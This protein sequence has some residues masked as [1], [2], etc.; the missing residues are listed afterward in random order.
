MISQSCCHTSV[1]SDD[2][3]T[4][5]VTNHKVTEK[6]VEDSGKMTLYNVS[7]TY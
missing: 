6:N 1:T 5:T 7:Y 2:T 4:A 3:V